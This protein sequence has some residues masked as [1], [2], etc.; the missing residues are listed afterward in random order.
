MILPREHLPLSFLDLACPTGH[1]PVCQSRFVE[2][3]I[4][5]LDLESRVGLAP[6]VLIARSETSGLTYA[7]ERYENNLYVVCKMGSWVDVNDLRDRAT[8]CSAALSLP[9]R[10]SRKGPELV[11]AAPP[12]LL[13]VQRKRRLALEAIQSLVRKKAKTPPPPPLSAVVA[14]SATSKGA[15]QEVLQGPLMT[16]AEGLDSGKFCVLDGIEGQEEPLNT[17]GLQTKETQQVTTTATGNEIL[18]NIRSQYFEALYK[19]KV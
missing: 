15:E 13:K 8:A 17:S 10:E 7:I 19:S 12:Q 6:V 4:K 14:V 9:K 3:S 5:A 2:S 1:L 11:P 16:E 18:E